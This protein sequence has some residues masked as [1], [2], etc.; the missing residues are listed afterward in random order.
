MHV[1]RARRVLAAVCQTGVLL[2][3]LST[4]AAAQS[5]ISGQVRD[6]SGAV[7]PGVLVEASSPVLIEKSR[8]VVTD[9]QGRYTMVDLRPGVYKIVF[10]LSGFATLERDGFELPANF[11]ATVNPELKIGALEE[12]VT[13]SGDSPIVDVQSSQKTVNLRREV[14]DA[15][16][17]ART[18]AAEGALAVGVK[19]VAQNVGG[20]RIAAQQRLYVHGA[21]AADNTVAVDGMSMN[22]TYSN[23]ETQPNHNDSMTQEVTVQTSTPGAEVSGG[24]LFIN[25]VPKEGGNRYSGS[26]FGGYTDH[27][28]QGD[29]LTPELIAKGLTTGD[30]V[31]YI[32]DVNAAFGGPIRE[33][34][35][36]FFGSYRNVG[37]ANIV[38]NSFYPDGSPGLYDQDVQNYTVRLTWQ[39][40]EKLKVTSYIDRV[41]KHVG[42]AFSSGEEVQFASKLWPTPLYYTGAVKLTSTLSD[43]FLLE[44]GFGASVNDISMKYQPGVAKERGTPEWYST[45]SRQDITLSTRTIA[46]TVENFTYPPVYQWAGAGTYVTGSNTLK[47]G[48]Q[49]R[50]GPYRVN[51]NA[52]ADLIQ[53]YRNGA[54]DSVIVYNLPQRSREHLNA[55]LGL[56]VQDSW[57]I[58]RLTL[59]PGIRYEYFDVT[60]NAMEVEGGRFTG[61]RS[62][63]EQKHAPEWSNISPR[64]GAVYDLRGDAKTA[65]RFGVNRYN[66]SYGLNATAPYDPMAL[67]SDTRNWADC[68]YLPGTSTCNPALIGAPGYRDNIVQDNEIGP[69]VTPF[70]NNRLLDPD[71]KRD[72]NIQYNAGVDHQLFSGVSVGFAWY[73]RN[74]YNLPIS[75]NQLVSYSD[76]TASQTINPYTGATMTLYNLDPAKAGQALFLDTTSNDRSK[77]RRDY[78][79][80]ELS[81]TIRLPRGGTFIGGWGGERTINATCEN[82]DPNQLYNCDQSQFDIPLRNDFKLVGTYPVVWGIQVGAVLQSYAGAAVPVSWSVPASAFPGGRRTQAVTLSTTV[83]GTGY[84]GSSLSDP[85]TQYLTRWHQLDLSF[86]KTFRIH[87]VNLDGSLDVFN[88]TN[89]SVVLTQNQACASPAVIT[90]IPACGTTLGAPQS[91]L[92]P[93]LFRLATT[94]KF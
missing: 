74:W 58:K 80:V 92:Q 44:G 39:A 51:T 38:A 68:A 12:T 40:A 61:F 6:T 72:Y 70:G 29:N 30:A 24:G 66:T 32:Y 77:T 1:L 91:I 18:Y 9:E 4:M 8:S 15:L 88:S 86:R 17:T 43:R 35:L 73:R 49:W 84:T 5:A 65:I 56:Y 48:G 11:T 33:N 28:F 87:G 2:L 62:Y 64:F 20:A 45:A 31:E 27:S 94:M 52:N 90:T 46:G 22:S 67:K 69:V 10:T 3:G 81:T 23:G 71:K 53:R 36:W 78:T 59:N 37:N 47:I 50:Y 79:G 75:V 57:T 25:L 55:D 93:R 83:V 54:P 13:V 16:P 60:I 63:P 34:K 14:L 82:P 85:G 42:H 21:A 76:Y 41:F 19:V 89:S 7:L 26:F